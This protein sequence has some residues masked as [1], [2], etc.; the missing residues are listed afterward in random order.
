MGGPMGRDLLPPMPD[1]ACFYRAIHGR[2]PFPW[3]DRLARHVAKTDEWP[4][5]IGVPT[6]LGKTVC[7]DV[8]IWWLAS[9]ADRVPA[10]RAAPT[11]IWW[12]VNRR[13]LVDSTFDHAECL[14]G[15]LKKGMGRKEP[16][17][18]LGAV[19]SRLCT[20][21]AGQGKPLEVV[22]LRGGV[23]QGRPTDPSQPAVIL[24]T[25]PM[26]GSRLLFR[27]YGS[28]ASMRPIDAAH[29][30]VDSLVL[31]D[32]AH[33]ARHLPRLI[34]SLTEC[35]PPRTSLIA[36]ARENPRLVAL[37]A[38]GEATGEDRFDLDEHDRSNKVV[39]ERLDAA[40]PMEL[41]RAAG[42]VAKALAE[43]TLEL[44]RGARE[45]A[46]FIVFANQPATARDV[47][48]RLRGKLPDV[49]LLTG[50]NREHEAKSI[51]R[52][53]MDKTAGMPA[54]RDP[55]LERASDLV[56]VA[57]QTLEVGADLDA[58][59]LVTEACGVR[60]LTQRLGRLNRLGRFPHARAV[61]VHGA[62]RKKSKGK[63][64]DRWPVYGAEPGFVLERLERRLGGA[65]SVDMSPHD[66]SDVLGA[67]C[68]EASRAPEILSGLL[69][70]WIKTTTPSRGE[71][72]VEPFFSGIADRSYA[73]SIIWRAHVPEEGRRLWPRSRDKEAV[74]VPVDEVR[75]LL[76]ADGEVRRLTADGVTVESCEVEKLR[77]GD[78]VVL[79][80]DRGFLD[81]F[82]WAPE[83]RSPVRDM[84]LAGQGLPLD[85]TALMR[86]WGRRAPEAE[87]LKPPSVL[88]LRDSIAVAVGERDGPEEVDDADQDRAVRAILDALE[89]A[90]P[91]AG[92]SEDEWVDFL[93]GLE[94]KVEVG[95][96][97]E[98]P[99]LAVSRKEGEREGATEEDERSF[100]EE[101]IFLESHADAV[102]GKAGRIAAQLGL[103]AMVAEA[104]GR[105][106]RLH[107]CGKAEPRFQ[108]WL[109]PGDREG[110]RL[111]AKSDYPRRLWE[112][113][114]SAA[115]W[116]RGG[117]HEALSARLV[118]A[119][120]DAEDAPYD[121]PLRD[122]LLHLVI[123]H[124][125]AGR[126]LVVPA[127]D[128]TAVQINA[129]IEGRQVS[130]PATLSDVDW[131]QP[132]RF[133]RLNEEYGPWGLALLEAILRQADHLVSSGT[134]GPFKREED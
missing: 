5:E 118:K 6:G 114:R 98:V 10:E 92:W 56:V 44:V 34:E 84:S 61:Y 51:R 36:I 26:Y 79:P 24:A 109:N 8:A 121:G 3:Q 62:P 12:V 38:T 76:K 63:E 131:N 134:G 35:F 60:A 2:N 65:S 94:P 41:R 27:G 97:N 23:S 127:S 73:V 9:Q 31:L 69:W 107:D 57:T 87:G 113:Y 101:A 43:A 85:A 90:D 49:V 20:I 39:R 74:D 75:D 30:G 110:G 132:R 29:A 42:S 95:A 16:N 89:A 80:S 64:P 37:T 55:D 106:G 70:E 22:R 59:Y 88:T 104:L 96:T 117:R 25:V 124:H 115:G 78:L 53:V 71:A 40:K 126:P 72:P 128:D 86:L 13:L 58:E 123:S 15:L 82:G 11:R 1:F 50:R 47:F 33:L 125:G 100:V 52:R 122:L 32:E 81:E 105:A 48:N 102:G 120:L 129:K 28:S 130:A 112:R 14:S 77:P 91:P 68:E 93:S 67:P 18:A 19:G 46:T 4:R 54:T 116:P 17:E 21:S 111:L 45:P 103:P 119:R 99:R 108:E 83:S 66:V 7:L 133:R